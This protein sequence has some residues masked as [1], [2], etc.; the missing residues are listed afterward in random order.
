MRRRQVGHWGGSMAPVVVRVL[1]A[2]IISAAVFLALAPGRHAHCAGPNE[3]E[4]STSDTARNDAVRAIPWKELDPEDRR[5]AE[6]VV[7]NTSIY[8]RMPTRVIDCDPDMFTMLCRRPEV[9]VNL[10]NV[11]GVSQMRLDRLSATDFRA[12]DPLGTEGKLRVIHSKY[13]P[14]AQN[15]LV[16]YV[17]GSCKS[18]PLPTPIEAKCLLLLR[19]GST[20][21]TNGRPYVAA[22]MDSFVV[23]ERLAAELVAKTIQPIVG[24]T[25]DQNFSETMK[26]LSTFSRTAERNP[27]GVINLTPRLTRVDNA[28]RGELVDQC[29]ATA[30]RYSQAQSAQPS[31][32]RLVQDTAG[33]EEP[34]PRGDRG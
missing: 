15:R 5:L 23:F 1:R 14:G 19:S 31:E 24:A 21:E 3:L 22:R 20:V 8:R 29:R 28:A 11:M 13:T 7:R 17:E 16:I 25:A 10:W 32:L 34:H 9:V 26:F 2:S 4:A 27:E 12:Q 33:V 18:A 30:R 6:G